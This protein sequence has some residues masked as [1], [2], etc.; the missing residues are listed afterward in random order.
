MDSISD[1]YLF[2]LL[3]WFY[4]ASN[5]TWSPPQHNF[6]LNRIL[7]PWT[8]LGSDL[9][10]PGLD[11]PLFKLKV[12]IPHWT[13]TPFQFGL[14]SSIFFLSSPRQLTLVTFTL[15]TYL[16]LT[17]IAYLNFI[18]APYP[19]LTRSHQCLPRHIRSYPAELPYS[20][21]LPIRLLLTRRYTVLPSRITL[22]DLF[23]IGLL[24]TRSYPATLPDF[25]TQSGNTS[26]H[27]TAYPPFPNHLPNW[28]P[29]NWTHL[30]TSSSA[31]ILT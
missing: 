19:S 6:Q 16:N 21:L 4:S 8:L 28:V 20:I 2:K 7:H 1:L 12:S 13:R 10:Y 30:K 11:S 9:V 25:L 26:L 18:W 5:P 14:V 17:W 3:T 29:F 22:P 27:P 24:P 31:P 23:P 15:S